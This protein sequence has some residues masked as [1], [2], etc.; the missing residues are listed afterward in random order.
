MSADG[1]T[2]YFD[3]GGPSGRC[4]HTTRATIDAPWEPRVDLGP[5]IGAGTGEGIISY[6][7]LE[8]YFISS[9][10][11]GGYGGWDTWVSTRASVSDPWGTPVNLGPTVNTPYADAPTW[12]SPDGLTLLLTSDRP[13]GLGNFDVWM[14]TRPSKASA[15]GQPRNLGSSINTIYAEEIMSVSLDGQWCY[16]DDFGGPHPGGLGWEDIWQVPILPIVDF[17]ADGKVDLDDLKLLIDNWGTDN[18]LYDIGPY[19][20]GDG[21]VDAQD[22]MVLAEHMVTETALAQ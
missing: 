19:A 17:N 10:W 5:A 9:S 21:I 15:W 20:W 12:I 22:L 8:L 13:G 3:S 4:Y 1:L 18:T 7:G 11:A 14:L 16:I 2:L 6:D